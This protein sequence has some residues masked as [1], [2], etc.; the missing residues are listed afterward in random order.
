MLMLL[1]L[2]LLLLL[3]SPDGTK[4]IPV[5]NLK[6]KKGEKIRLFLCPAQEAGHIA[7]AGSFMA[8]LAGNATAQSWTPSSSCR[9]SPFWGLTSLIFRGSSHHSMSRITPSSAT[10]CDTREWVDFSLLTATKCCK[11][12]IICMRFALQFVC[13]TI[14][15]MK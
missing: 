4:N 15:Q 8:D 3:L 9:S 12:N 7:L 13:P 11:F 1:L 14:T 5:I 6:K 2:L 10:E